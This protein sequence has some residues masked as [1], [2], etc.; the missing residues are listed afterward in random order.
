MGFRQLI[1]GV[2]PEF[3]APVS[4]SV[5]KNRAVLKSTRM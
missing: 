5:E 1:G 3:E 2:N 4:L